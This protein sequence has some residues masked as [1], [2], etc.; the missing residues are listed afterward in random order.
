MRKFVKQPPLWNLLKEAKFWSHDRSTAN[1]NA[2][3]LWNDLWLIKICRHLDF[4][5]AWKQRHEEEQKSS[6]LSEKTYAKSYYAF[7]PNYATKMLPTATLKVCNIMLECIYLV[8]Y[9]L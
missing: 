3:S 5:K 9:I 1:R 8:I 4:S 6:F 7:L 2:L